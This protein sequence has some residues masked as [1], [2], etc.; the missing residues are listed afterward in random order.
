MARPRRHSDE[1]LLAAARAVFL[2]QGP[3]ASLAVV[4]ER[5][6]MSQPALSQRFGS[7]QALLLRALMP[8]SNVPW[9]ERLADGPGPEPLRDQLEALC[10]EAMQF[11]AEMVPA[12]TALR[13]A[14]LPLM[15][16]LVHHPDAP[17]LR[18]RRLLIDWFAR[19]I[20]AGRLRAG[21]PERL[22]MVLIGGLESRALLAWVQ[23]ESLPADEQ[24]AHATAVADLL[25][26]GV[27]PESER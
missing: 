6:G 18:V 20:D 12:M 23:S 27:H 1:H 19:A 14:G 22:A 26:S 10:I 2:E 25:W 11:L 8:P 3:H 5:V 15:D 4:A 13:A 16:A 9:A 17:H 24:T 7:K 21:D